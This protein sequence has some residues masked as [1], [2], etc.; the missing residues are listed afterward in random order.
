MK[1]LLF[2]CLVVVGTICHAQLSQETVD[3]MTW[4][5]MA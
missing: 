1:N 2:L 3:A 5:S 4:G